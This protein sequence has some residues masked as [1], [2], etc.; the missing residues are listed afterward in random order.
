MSKR[1]KTI[2]LNHIK[3]FESGELVLSKPE[4]TLPT[5]QCPKCDSSDVKLKG[6]GKTRKNGSRGQII[7]CKACQKTSTVN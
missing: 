1:L 7:L 5:L 6:R 4:S 3:K 2:L